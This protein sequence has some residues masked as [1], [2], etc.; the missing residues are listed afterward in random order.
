MPYAFLT[1][2]PEGDDE[3]PMPKP[4]TF[5]GNIEVEQLMA[6]VKCVE[7]NGMEPK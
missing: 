2:Y 5:E 6:I 1:Y 4:V 7:E 3:D